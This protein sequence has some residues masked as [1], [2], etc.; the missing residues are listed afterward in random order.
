MEETSC[1]AISRLSSETFFAE[2]SVDFQVIKLFQL[3]W[4]VVLW[5]GLLLV[6]SI[7]IVYINKVCNGV[8]LVLM[9]ILDVK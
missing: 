2:Q 1:R 9:E 5:E 8:C 4:L 6:S 7:H 3:S